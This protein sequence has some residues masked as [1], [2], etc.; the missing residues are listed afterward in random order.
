VL[1][2]ILYVVDKRDMPLQLLLSV[3]SPLLQI[4]TSID[5]FHSLFQISLRIAE[6]IV[7]SPALINSAGI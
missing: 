5:P 4:D 1:D 2:K 6:R 7:L 3:S